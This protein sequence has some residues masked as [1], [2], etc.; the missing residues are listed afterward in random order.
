MDNE[1]IAVAVGNA[2]PYTGNAPFIFISYHPDDE[3]IIEPILQLMQFRGLRFWFS[4]G[5]APGTERD[6]VIAEHIEACDYFIAFVSERY[7][8]TLDTTD[9]LNYSRDLNK[10]QLLI[11]LSP[12][13]LPIGMRMRMTRMQSLNRYE[14]SSDQDLY[15]QILLIEGTSRFYGIDDRMLAEKAEPLFHL[16]ESYYP[17]HLVFSLDGIDRS[18][19]ERIALLCAKTEFES[20]DDLMKAYGFSR[21]TGEEA[22]N[23]RRDVSFLPGDEPEIIQ[24]PLKTALKKLEQYY[25]ERVIVDSL[26]RFHNAL[27]SRL[28]ALHQWL[29]Y[30]DLKEFLSAYSFQYLYT[31]SLGRTGHTAEE[32]QALF[33]LIREKYS[34]DE[35]PKSVAELLHD[36]PQYRPIFKTLQNNSYDLFG[37]SFKDYLISAGLLQMRDQAG[38]IPISQAR[39]MEALETR[40]GEEQLESVLEQL[41]GLSLRVTRSGQI[42]VYRADECGEEVIIPKAIDLIHANAFEDQLGLHKITISDGCNTIGEKAFCNC[43]SL[44]EVK[45]PE[46]LTTIEAGTFEGCS[47]LREITI[48]STVLKIYPLAFLNCSKLETVHLLNPKTSIYSGAFEG[49]LYVPPRN[50]PDNVEFEYTVDKKNRATIIGLKGSAEILQIP[51]IL[52]GHPVLSVDKGAFSDHTELREVIMADSISVL[53]GDAFKDCTGLTRLHIS[54]SVSKLTPSSF[55]GCT[56]LLEVNIPD[57]LTELKRNTF[58]DAQLEALHIGKSIRA[59]DPNAFFRGEFDLTTGSLI[60]GKSIC[61]VD[62]SPDNPWLKADGTCLFSS[63]GKVLF[64]DLG[65]TKEYIIPEGVEEIADSAFCRNP[66]LTS[67]LF[68]KSLKKIGASAFA[69]TG[70]E[71]IVLHS[72]LETIKEKAFSFCRSLQQVSF[73]EGLVEIGDQVFEG[74]PIRS[75]VLPASLQSL[76]KNVFPILSI[77]Q[78][79]IHQEFSV[80]PGNPVYHDDGL[81][82]YRRDAERKTVVKAYGYDFRCTSPESN[83][84]PIRYAIEPGTTNIEEN[85]FFR[86]NNL[87]A[88]L[89]PDGL[90]EIG[91]RAFMDCTKLESADL[92]SSVIKVESSAFQGTKIPF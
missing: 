13:E 83:Q 63:D 37:T 68:P 92:P 18:L 81:V 28:V 23:Y 80:M 1:Q 55:S 78:G 8:Q 22:K 5:I 73:S 15:E 91:A 48:P 50:H 12:A 26:P 87:A 60:K 24:L 3:E 70:L 41:E 9:E 82:L 42:S 52:D 57:A 43:S 7:L 51:D 49:C 40:V 56:S 46:G 36:F 17:D 4:A 31:P 47:E 38:N 11:Y 58:R 69:E 2:I 16:L 54:D 45:L 6:E 59:L 20:V 67:V 61:S 71:S 76:G 10:D 33:N 75:I 84:T 65:D 74:C 32:Y 44:E 77:Y 25:P 39:A 90:Q 72:S 53:Q 88:V 85:A 79:E 30:I 89:F 29:G 86:C 34:S 27:N 64:C 19:R 62:V 14:L 21:I 66:H 35:R